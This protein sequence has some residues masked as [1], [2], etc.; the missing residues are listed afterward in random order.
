M[1]LAPWPGHVYASKIYDATAVLGTGDGIVADC[2]GGSWA[3]RGTRHEWT[4]SSGTVGRRG[5]GRQRTRAPADWDRELVRAWSMEA[6]ACVWACRFPHSVRS[7]SCLAKQLAAR[8]ST[9]RLINHRG[10]LGA[11]LCTEVCTQV[12]SPGHHQRGRGKCK[13]D[14]VV[15]SQWT[16]KGDG[17][18]G[19]STAPFGLLTHCTAHLH[20]CILP[21]RVRYSSKQDTGQC[22]YTWTS[23]EYIIRIPEPS[24]MFQMLPVTILN[25][26]P[27]CRLFYDIEVGERDTRSRDFWVSSFHL[28]Y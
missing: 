11:C 21:S 26:C 9:S 3:A 28:Y 18:D 22:R 12:T 25:N 1:R 16:R 7:T 5:L 20:E 2:S 13:C 14:R 24:R 23:T 17:A 15:G 8:P 4:G 6:W 10:V 19:L 27:I